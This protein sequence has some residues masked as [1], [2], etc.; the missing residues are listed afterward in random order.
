MADLWTFQTN[1]TRGELDPQLAGRIDLAAYYS[2][3]ETATNV[4]A[5]PQGGLKKRPG[6]EIIDEKEGVSPN[7]DGRLENF[8]FNTEQNYVLVF[9]DFEMAIYKD[10]VLQTNI[11]G[12]GDDFLVTPWSIGTLP[13]M[14]YVQSA[15]TAVVVHPNVAP[16]TITRTG[17]TLWAITT[18][19]FTEVPQFDYN[20]ASSPTPTSEIQTINFANQ[21]LG[22]R[23]KISLEGILT[24]EIIQINDDTTN[25]ENLRT[26]LQDLPNTGN[27]GITVTTDVALDTYR[28]TFADASAKPWDFLS[29]T[30]ISTASTAFNAATTRIQTGVSRA[31]DTWSVARGFPSTVT[32]HEGRLWLGGSK[33]RPATLFGSRVG[34]F[35][36]FRKGRANDDES[37]EAT[38]DTDQIN[39]IENI[40]SNRSLQVFTSG[41]EF[42]I[43]E[44][45]ITPS[46]IAVVP[47][48]NL[49]SKRV[50]P[51]TIDGVTLFIQRTGRAIN[52]FVFVNEL[53]SNQS[54]S[55]SVLAQHLINDPIKMAVK[56]GSSSEDANYV[57]ILNDDGDLTVFN[58]LISEDVTA[59]TTWET[60]DDIKS[61]AVV[62]NSL[63]LLM[64][65]TVN[66]VSRLYIEKENSLLNTDSGVR[67][68][69]LSSKILTGLDHL[70]G[71]TVKVK[72]D[73]AAQDDEIVSGGQISVENTSD[74]IE[75]GLEYQPTI[76][77]L[78]LNV[79]LRDGF[80]AASKKRIVRSAIHLYLSNGVIVNGQRI[81]D[82]TIGQDQFDAPTP[83]SGLKRV[84]LHGW[85]LEAA[86]TIT[87][88]TPMQFHIL[89]VGLEVKT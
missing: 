32:F 67:K 80:N 54:R 3:V 8:S 87:Q 72:A 56:R 27:S 73:G 38:L 57:Y 68:T 23:Y 62:D 15:D 34:D 71:E 46:N 60:V 42:N 66:G 20:D 14:D 16:R 43:K 21:A 81:A 2:G 18:I 35:F 1:F 6:Q 31:E 26:G 85:S 5:T 79:Q 9:T 58:T 77:T 40:F 39:A 24:E 82:K 30:A 13:D 22:D 44:S 47:Q 11:N 28:I 4:L 63:Y 59:F 7:F 10:D 29:V 88:D 75:A 74:T 70:N 50:R 64:H 51:V 49:G 53:Q 84:F 78:P 48:S 83:Q 61:I 37:V 55:V 19:V 36:N 76:K 86:I 33:S 65:R 69:G 17:D 12:S 52:Q 45:P 41:A 25:E 89:S